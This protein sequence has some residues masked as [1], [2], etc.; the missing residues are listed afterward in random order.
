MK[1]PEGL[2]VPGA[3][4]SKNEA[5]GPCLPELTE[6]GGDTTGHRERGVEGAFGSSPSSPRGPGALGISLREASWQKTIWSVCVSGGAVETQ[7]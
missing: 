3:G 4:D 7:V 1:P 6:E 5:T 2:Y